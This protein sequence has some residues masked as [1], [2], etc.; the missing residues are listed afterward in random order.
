MKTSPARYLV[1]LLGVAIAAPAGVCAAEAWWNYE[2]KCRRRV[3]LPKTAGSRLP[4]DDI[5]VVSMSTGGRTRPDA[6]D[7]RVTTAR[8]REMP[9]RV[10]MIG[11]GDE[12]RVAFAIQAG[13]TEYYVYYA[14]PSPPKMPR[15]LTVK[16]GVLLSTWKYPGGSIGTFDKVKRIFAKVETLIGRDFRDRIFMGYNPFG[17]QDALASTFVAYLKCPKAGKYTFST[18]SQNAS[19]LTVDA[20]LVVA[21]GGSHGPQRDIRKRGDVYMNA[22]LRKLAFY[23]V[24]PRGNPVVVVAWRPPGEKRIRVIP[25]S[26]Y[27]PIVRGKSGN[28]EELGKAAADFIPLHAGEVFMMNR[29]YQRY[30]FQ[31]VQTGPKAGNQVIQWTWDFGDG[32]RASGPNVQ[33]VYFRNGTHTVTLAGKTRAAALR[34]RNKIY[35]TRPWQTVTRNRLESIRD[36]AKIAAEYSFD[37]LGPLSM[38][39]AAYLFRRAGDSRALMKV[40]AAFVSRRSVEKNTATL[41]VPMYAEA[42]VSAGQAKTALDAFLAGAKLESSP[43][44]S[45]Q[46]LVLAGRVCVEHLNDA[47]KA[48]ELFNLAVRKYGAV[49]SSIWIRRGRIGVGDAWR[50]LGDYDKARS[51]YDTAGPAPPRKS[52]GQ[53]L[54]RGDFARQIEDYV[55][56]G[57]LRAAAE[58]IDQWQNAFPADKLDGYWSLLRAKLLVRKKAYLAAAREAEILVRVTPA[59]HHAP[60][61][62]MLAAEAYR[63]GGKIPQATATLKRVIKDYPESALAAKAAQLLKK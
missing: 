45:A 47:R 31:A 42:L 26:A 44:G 15:E 36:Y 27:A 7:V 14:N 34:R 41:L 54:A 43:V 60:E 32:E 10:L 11:P 53:A 16:R 24:S 52:G 46:L 38:V 55:R 37:K 21:N 9:S 35:V 1:A 49:S 28:M 63:Q 39:E 2:W 13:V 59:S 3:T 51:A 62:L 33:H 40:G 22:G 57:D 5:A 17:P 6:K 56:R 23:H 19:F 25:P 58:R 29:Y 12:V 8:R 61:L 4:G 18:S 50:L 48:M 30:T 20:R